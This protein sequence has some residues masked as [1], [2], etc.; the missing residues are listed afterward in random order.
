MNYYYHVTLDY[1]AYFEEQTQV[2]NAIE[3]TW[4]QKIDEESV[5]IKQKREKLEHATTVLSLK[6][7]TAN[8]NP[9]TVGGI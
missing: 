6:N 3:I 9:Q 4:F 8:Q 1:F 2:L 5:F 7:P